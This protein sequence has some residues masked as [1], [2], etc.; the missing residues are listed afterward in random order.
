MAVQPQPIICE[1]KYFPTIKEFAN[2]YG[3]NYS[4]AQYY[5][6][7]GKTPEEIISACQFS[8]ASK[9]NA[10]PKASAKRFLCEYQGVQYSSLYEAASA[11]G[12]SP[13]KLYELRKRKNLT[14]SDA[15]AE[16]MRLEESNLKRDEETDALLLLPCKYNGVEYNSLYDAAT[17]LD[18]SPSQL[19]ELRKRKKLSPSATVELA[20]KK[21][22]ENGKGPSRVAKKC[23]VDGVEYESR[24]AAIKAYH[25]PRITVYSRMERE[26]IS[27]EEAL[28]RGRKAVTYCPPTISLYPSLRLLPTNTPLSQPI[29][30]DLS[31]SLE[32]YNRPVQALRDVVTQLPAILADNNT[33]LF[34]N[35]EARGL[36]MVSSLPFSIDSETLNLLNGSYVAAKLFI[37][38][39]SGQVFMTAFQIAKEEGQ[40]IKSLLYGYFSF[41]SLRDQLIRTYG[42]TTEST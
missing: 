13:N 23:V 7:R 28:S 30:E 9:A 25:V 36:E 32:Y 38:Q 17:A 4:K 34:L 27:F 19:Y 26:G 40:D 29:L 11:L 8:S 18:I 2:Y 3:L 12:I 16:A 42:E 41:A 24:E 31:S 22:K 14:P 33:Y 35:H 1:G 37:S 5:K 21:R 20:M 39:L 15:I 10:Q 6:K